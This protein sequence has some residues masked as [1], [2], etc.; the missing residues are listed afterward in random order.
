M[1]RGEPRTKAAR[2][3]DTLHGLRL[4]GH[5][6]AERRGLRQRLLQCRVSEHLRR[7]RAPQSVAVHRARGKTCFLAF[8][9]IDDGCCEQRTLHG[10][11]SQHRIDERRQILRGQA[12]PRGVVHQHPI[13]GGSALR[14]R[15]QAV[16]NRLLPRR[17]AYGGAQLGTLNRG[18]DAGPAGVISG[19]GND[20][21][22]DARFAE[23]GVQRPFEH[24]STDQR[25]VLFG[26][27]QRRGI[28]PG[29]TPGR[30]N[31]GPDVPQRPLRVRQPRIHCARAVMRVAG[32]AGAGVAA[33][34]T[35]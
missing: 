14:E 13:I 26:S 22:L 7:Q 8:D 19:E 10:I 18:F 12:R 34:T 29:A 33:V 9:R 2:I 5:R 1:L 28:E 23:Q 30:G 16:E 20:D 6:Q 21:A 31:H 32:A 35:W 24:G 3:P 25:R 4:V 27:V 11:R 15:L 17:R